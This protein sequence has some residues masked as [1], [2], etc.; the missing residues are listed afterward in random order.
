MPKKWICPFSI[1]SVYAAVLEQSVLKGTYSCLFTF[2]RFGPG[3]NLVCD[4]HS[5]WS[6]V[7]SETAGIDNGNN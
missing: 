6:V 1:T 7:L 3:A 2:S 5:D 4:G